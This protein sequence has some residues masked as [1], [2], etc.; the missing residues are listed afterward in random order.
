MIERRANEWAIK[1][2]VLA[3]VGCTI[4]AFLVLAG[5][6]ANQAVK[7]S[8]VQLIAGKAVEREIAEGEAH[9]YSLKLEEGEFVHLFIYQRG[10]NVSAT[11]VGPDGGK[12]LEADTPVSTQ[13][14]E[15]ITH[16]AAASGEYRVEVRV[17]DKGAPAGR[18]E[19]KVE[20]QRKT[21]SGD[22]IRLSAQKDFSEGNRLY[23]EKKEESYRKAIDKYKEAV[24]FFRQA[25]RRTEEAVTLNCAARA[26][27]SVN[28]H[29]AAIEH[30][31]TALSIYRELKDVH[32]EGFALNRIGNAY[33]NTKRYEEA[34][35]Y[36]EQAVEARRKVGYRA[37]EGVALSNLGLAYRDLNR[38][39]KA[40][41]SFEQALVIKREV[42]DRRGESDVL[43]NLGYAYD[44]LDRYEQAIQHYEQALAIKREIKDQEGEGYSL[45]ALGYAYDSLRRYEEA[46]KFFEQA[47]VIKRD[48][49]DRAGEGDSLNDL[50]DAYYSLNRHEEAIKYYEQSLAIKRELKDR[51]VEGDLLSK[52]GYV[53]ESLNQREKAIGYYE[54]A[55]AIFREAKNRTSE[56]I[57]LANLGSAYDGL[58]RYEKAIEYYEQSLAIDREVKDRTGEGYALAN[59]GNAYYSLSRYEKAIE[60]YEQALAIFREVKTRAA[61]GATLS[62]LG[63]VY[64]GLSRYEK[65]IEYFEQALAISQ[66]MKNQRGIAY[67]LQGLGNADKALSRYEKAI[68]YYEQSLAIF[69]DVKDRSSEGLALNNLMLVWEV[70]SNNRV[71][72]FY[73]K[74]AVNVYQEIRGNIK[75][76]D[77]ESQQ[78]FLR[79]KESTYRTLADLLL[80]E[81]R[82]PEAEEVLALLKEEEFSKIVRRDGPISSGIRFNKSESEGVK[83]SDQLA[84]LARERSAIFTR[85]ENKT[86]TADD[87]RRMDEIDDKIKIANAEFRRAMTEIAKAPPDDT[88]GLDAAKESQS[89]M[90]DLRT[91]G[92]GTVALYTVITKEKGWILMVTADSRKAYSIDVSGL[93]QTIAQ[94]RET[95]KS[96]RH[97]PLPFA[98]KLYRMIMESPQKEG[99]TLAEDLRLYGAKTLMWSL[100]GVLR[101]VPVAVLHD[102]KNYLVEKYINVV[103]TT[104]SVSRLNAAVNGQWRG[105]GLGVSKQYGRF[106]ALDGVERELRSI[107]FEEAGGKREGMLAG[108]IRLNEA[109]NKKAMIDG[110]REGFAVV[111]IASHFSFNTTDEAQ[112]FLLLGDGNNL[113]LEE[114]QDYQNIFEKVE[115]LTLSACDTAVGGANGKEVEGLAYLAQK[116]GAKAVVASLWPVADTGA[117]VLMREFYYERTREPGLTKAEAFQQAQIDLLRGKEKSLDAK[118]KEERSRGPQVKAQK[119]SAGLSLYKKDAS[120]PFAHP[121]YWAPFILI[122]NWK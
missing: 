111:H 1:H 112:S 105:L 101:Y 110:L 70:Q 97:D 33:L 11:L 18:Y 21:A 100:D 57:I 89:L 76:L 39:E 108:Q 49:K 69:R 51:R 56:S 99:A 77:T 59:I 95:L 10:V 4:A 74:Q 82:L 116:L 23:G 9:F 44:S 86:A 121:H 17:V 107:I 118:E 48:L 20:E 14:A 64:G 62:N 122:G 41:E 66:E 7:P 106:A 52:L 42:K 94:L 8:D 119:S 113:T 73:G 38:Y 96:D 114:L 12:L 78:S 43:N 65:A 47:L 22:D 109:F 2:N 31:K 71:A 79:D 98:R 75:T 45:K 29:P 120:A 32:G 60:Y 5:V 36:Y 83:A 40:I 115:L 92:Q 103:F 19:I 91:L 30:Y 58:S 35:I 3:A 46:I 72:I 55:L 87:S 63:N 93:E 68:E 80:S 15:W 102:G 81:G 13:E 37:G 25:G 28:D 85:L 26:H 104:A 61:E 24:G 53:Y 34:I 27:A 67:A 16:I 117:E 88:R 90:P 50:G 54:Q 6:E 84:L